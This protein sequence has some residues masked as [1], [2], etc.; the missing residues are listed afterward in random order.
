MC[1]ES[2]IS[3]TGLMLRS[4]VHVER[5]KSEE[6]GYFR[7]K[8]LIVLYLALKFHKWDPESTSKRIN[9]HSSPGP[10][11]QGSVT[12][13][14]MGLLIYRMWSWAWF[15]KRIVCSVL[16]VRGFREELSF[17]EL[18]RLHSYPWE[19]VFLDGYPLASP[20]HTHTTHIWALKQHVDWLQMERGLLCVWYR[21]WTRGDAEW[22]DFCSFETGLGP[23]SDAP[24]PLPPVQSSL[25]LEYVTSTLM[26]VQKP[27][28]ERNR[29][30][31]QLPGQ[32]ADLW[33]GLA[34]IQADVGHPGKS[35]NPRIHKKAA[36]DN[37]EK[38][39]WFSRK[40]PAPACAAAATFYS[41]N[42]VKAHAI[43]SE[44]DSV[45]PSIGMPRVGGTHRSWCH[46]TPTQDHLWE[47]LNDMCGL[48]T[49]SPES[50]LEITWS[51][52]RLWILQKQ[53][54]HLEDV[55]TTWLIVISSFSSNMAV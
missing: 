6:Y 44:A 5:D 28:A 30:W 3:V 9:K 38:R 14:L 22:W 2:R 23:K 12:N 40:C 29:E 49:S 55:N 1:S 26:T 17:P 39:K 10:G 52:S 32:R 24:P 36:M 42:V 46:L 19:K 21:I 41:L 35:K 18:S 7:A 37:Q 25:A 31:V 4:R 54:K 51:K 15:T 53:L 27:G 50:L 45:Y 33:V 13:E 48:G 20:Q 43:P 16:W 8:D 34:I 11:G 47:L